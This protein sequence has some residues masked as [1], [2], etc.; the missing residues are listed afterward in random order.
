MHMQNTTNEKVML[1]VKDIMTKM[2]IGRDRAYEIIKMG[3]FHTIK[4]GRKY[5]VHEDV[6]SDWLKGIKTNRK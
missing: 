1:G 4:L 2:Q 5:Y 6:F 3:E